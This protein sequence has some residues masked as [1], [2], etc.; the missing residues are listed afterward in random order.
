MADTESPREQDPTRRAA[1]VLARQ[2]AGREAGDD[3]DWA[4]LISGHP[5]LEPELASLRDNWPRVD[6]LLDA[7]GLSGTLSERIKNRYGV[8][9]GGGRFRL[10]R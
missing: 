10:L 6:V 5:E 8:G 1:S 2:L 7:L 3:I 9:R 4:G